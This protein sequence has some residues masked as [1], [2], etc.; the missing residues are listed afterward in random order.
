MGGSWRLK[1]KKLLKVHIR[2]VNCR[3]RESRG[4]CGAG[5]RTT[6]LPEAAGLSSSGAV[7]SSKSGGMEQFWALSSHAGFV[8]GLELL[9][10]LTSE[11]TSHASQ[12]ELLLLIWTLIGS[13]SIFSFEKIRLSLNFAERWSW[14]WILCPKLG[15]LPVLWG[16]TRSAPKGASGAASCPGGWGVHSGTRGSRPRSSKDLV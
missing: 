8:V 1:T 3:A 11:L 6:G 13:I 2:H 7:S 10:C 15:C 16:F 9:A 12:G 4:G 14:P 5:G